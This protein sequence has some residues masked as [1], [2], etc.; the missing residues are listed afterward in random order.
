MKKLAVFLVAML[1]TLMLPAQPL[2]HRGGNEMPAQTALVT[3]D[4]F[5]NGDVIYSAYQYQGEFYAS[6]ENPAKTGQF[7]IKCMGNDSDTP[8]KTGV[9]TDE[10][11]VYV[12]LRNNEYSVVSLTVTRNAGYYYEGYLTDTREPIVLLDNLYYYLCPQWPAVSEILPYKKLK[13]GYFYFKDFLAF[14]QFLP[15][16]TTSISFALVEGDGRLLPPAK[17]TNMP[18]MWRYQF[19]KSDFTRGY[20]K[21]KVRGTPFI[22]CPDA[23]V[24]KEI[25]ILLEQ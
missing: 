12:L 1:V 23:Q 6:W 22:K 19:V 2:T 8:V 3:F 10:N 9:D 7:F 24:E 14:N 25:T 20:I 18:N 21:L 13:S 11:P 5:Q 4:D 16:Y 17:I 15:K